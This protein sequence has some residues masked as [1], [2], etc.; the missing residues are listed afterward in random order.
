M[1]KILYFFHAML[2]T[3]LIM[4][5]CSDDADVTRPKAELLPLNWDMFNKYKIE[6]LINEYGKNSADYNSSRPPY[7]VFDW[8]NTSI[9]LDIEEAVLIYQIENLVFGATPSQLNEAIRKDIES[10]NFESDYNNLSG[11]SVNIEKIAPDI[12]ESYTWL[13]NNYKNLKGTQ[14]LEDVKK[15]SHYMAFA[16]KLRY[17]Y[18]AIG[19]TFDHAVSYPWVTYLFVGMT[20]TEVRTLTKATIQWQLSQSV[21]K[22]IWT[23]PEDLPGTAG[24]VS[25]S[26]KNGLRFVPEMQNL[27]WIFKQNGFDV[28]VC[29]ASF[30]DV[31]KEISSNPGNGYNLPEDHVFAMELERDNE[32]KIKVQ[33]KEGYAQTQGEGKTKTIQQFL[34]SKYGYGPIFIAGDSEGDQNMM[35][36]FEDTRL[37]LIINRLRSPST[38][39]GQ[40]SKQAVDTYG[41]ANAKYLLQGRNDNT[42]LFTQSQSSYS[43]GSDKAE[44]L[45]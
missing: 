37:V 35:K 20:E 45:K 15:S 34:V 18:D 43:L 32:G 29:S 5:G 33:F 11:G 4:T 38:D 25:V 9:F 21:G 23:T 16:S 26:W 42:G 3:F 36:D 17:L 28:W 7:V 8:D 44:L 24:R 14:T 41:D 39:I 2:F 1:K 30:I 19:G 27:Y 12:I 10:K 31:V 6:K 22:V 13:Y 40:M